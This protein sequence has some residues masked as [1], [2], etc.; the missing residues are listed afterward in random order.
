MRNV[1]FNDDAVEQI[2]EFQARPDQLRARACRQLG[3]PRAKLIADQ[4][5]RGRMVGRKS[6]D[7]ACARRFTLR[8]EDCGEA[9]DCI[10]LQRRH[11]DRERDTQCIG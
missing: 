2:V 6:E 8:L 1:G 3:E 11:T 4:P 5:V 9:I 7:L 10:K